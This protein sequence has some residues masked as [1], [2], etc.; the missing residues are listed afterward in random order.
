[1]GVGGGG[2]GKGGVQCFSR[3]ALRFTRCF[4]S[5]FFL[6]GGGGRGEEGGSQMSIQCF[7]VRC[8]KTALT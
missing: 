4:S 1:M 2:G 7:S 6:G 8:G 3:V 5:S